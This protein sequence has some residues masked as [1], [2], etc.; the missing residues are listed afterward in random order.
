[1]ECIFFS[2]LTSHHQ[3]CAIKIEDCCIVVNG[4]VSRELDYLEP[5]RLPNFPIA[6]HS[7][8][9]AFFEQQSDRGFFLFVIIPRQTK[10]HS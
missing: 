3:L 8:G 4:E 9:A 7:T 10:N 6:G 1:M 2:F 5:A